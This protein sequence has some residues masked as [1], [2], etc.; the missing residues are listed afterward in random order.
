MQTNNPTIG[1][2]IAELEQRR[3]QH[4]LAGQYDEFRALCHPQLRYVHSSGKVDDYAGYTSKC[5]QG[6]YE[7]RVAD[8]VVENVQ[9]F[10]GVATLFA[11]LKSEFMAGTELKKLHLKIL[12]VWVLDDGQWKFF[13]YQPTAI[14]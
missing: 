14:V 12:S 9:V 6:F 8:L 1:K 3:Y 5:D 13:A 4:L 10:D 2:D 7:Y 11:E